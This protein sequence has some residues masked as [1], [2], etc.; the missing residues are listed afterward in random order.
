MHLSPDLA[1]RR[2]GR[3]GAE[4]PPAPQFPHGGSRSRLADRHAVRQT[5]GSDLRPEQPHAPSAGAEYRWHRSRHPL[6][7]GVGNAIRRALRSRIKRVKRGRHAYSDRWVRPLVFGRA[8]ACC[9]MRRWLQGGCSSH[10]EHTARIDRRKHRSDARSDQGSEKGGASSSRPGAQGSASRRCQG[11][12]EGGRPPEGSR[13]IP[14]GSS[15]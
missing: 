10:F 5:A 15:S 8:G 3:T 14:E 9:R 13:R 11:R 4:G 7:S 2:S 1:S 6:L 12:S